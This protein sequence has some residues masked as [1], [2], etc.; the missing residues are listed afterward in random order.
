MLIGSLSLK[1]YYSDNYSKLYEV[2]R[3]FGQVLPDLQKGRWVAVAKEIP[4]DSIDNSKLSALADRKLLGHTLKKACEYVHKSDEIKLLKKR[5]D[6]LYKSE[7]IVNEDVAIEKLQAILN[8]E[9]DR[10]VAFDYETT[11]LKPYRKEHTIYTCGFATAIDK[12]FAFM[13]TPRTS[14]YVRKIVAS[15]KIPKVAANN[16]F[17]YIWTLEKLGTHANNLIYDCCLNAHIQDPRRGVAGVKFRALVEFGIQDYG[18]VMEPY[19]KPTDTM[20]AKYGAN[21]VNRITQAPRQLLLQYNA[22]D[23]L[24]EYWLADK[25]VKEII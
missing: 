8:G 11:G 15:A 14:D 19:F 5:A 22:M 9:Y 1:T 18:K 16:G 2:D 6:T 24:I 7:F 13:M 25:H 4:N 21:A 12:C 3:L 20:T 10:F 23:A 17:E